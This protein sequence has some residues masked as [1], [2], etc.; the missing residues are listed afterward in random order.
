MHDRRASSVTEAV[1]FLAGGKI[2]L[3]GG[4]VQ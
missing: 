3:A 2:P 4:T 1:A